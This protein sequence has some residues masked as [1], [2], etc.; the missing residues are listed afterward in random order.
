MSMI[1]PPKA[2]IGIWTGG[3]YVAGTVYQ[4]LSNGF[5]CGSGGDSGGQIACYVD[6]FTPPTT[7]RTGSHSQNLNEATINFPVKK[8]EYWKVTCTVGTIT[9]FFRSL[10]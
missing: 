6:P 4:A 8:N 7:R 3:P 5:I 2:Q 9:V 10:T 1:S